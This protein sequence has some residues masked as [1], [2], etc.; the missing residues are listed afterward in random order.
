[1]QQSLYGM[2]IQEKYDQHITR[3]SAQ[4]SSVQGFYN[5]QDTER[6]QE[7][8]QQMSGQKDTILI[9]TKLLRC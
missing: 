1:M 8:H 5:S 2:Y 6:P 7:F 4:P 3:L 9:T